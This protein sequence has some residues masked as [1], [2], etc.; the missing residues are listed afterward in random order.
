MLLPPHK[1]LEIVENAQFVDEL[2]EL[3]PDAVR[4]DE[5]VEGAKFV[6]SRNPRAGTMVSEHVWFLPMWPEP[7]VI[8]YTFDEDHV[9]LLS[10]EKTKPAGED[11]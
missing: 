4:A 10:I 2:Q 1:L 11:E 9:Y 8:F 7:A 5:F 3:E 6:L